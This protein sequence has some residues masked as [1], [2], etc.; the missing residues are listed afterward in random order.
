MRMLKLIKCDDN[1]DQIIWL[2][3]D[4]VREISWD[5]VKGKA[6]AEIVTP[7]STFSVS[8]TPDEIVVMM[9]AEVIENGTEG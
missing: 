5:I 9:G 8:E 3:A 6:G 7:R 2:R 4:D 1:G